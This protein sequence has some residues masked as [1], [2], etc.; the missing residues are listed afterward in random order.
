MRRHPTSELIDRI[1]RSRP[2]V[3]KAREFFHVLRRASVIP[4][5]TPM[6]ATT[7]ELAPYLDALREWEN[8]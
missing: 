6:P 1:E 8:R 4:F 3:S 2:S 5:E 7:A